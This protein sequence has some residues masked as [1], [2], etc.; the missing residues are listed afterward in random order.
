M[1]PKP[2]HTQRVRHKARVHVGCM[3]HAHHLPALG[4][5]HRDQI[6]PPLVSGDAGDVAAPRPIRC[7]GL[8]LASQQF[9]R[10]RQIVPAIGGDDELPLAPCSYAL[11]L[12]QP[13]HPVLANAHAT[14]Q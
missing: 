6:Q 3:L 7:L 12:H 8:E 14:V 9:R 2:R 5:H 10:H 1:A 4:V 11:Q 13:L